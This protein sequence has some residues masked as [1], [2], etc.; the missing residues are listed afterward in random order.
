MRLIL[1]LVLALMAL[2]YVVGRFG[3]RKKRKRRH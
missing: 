1:T 3:G 2:V